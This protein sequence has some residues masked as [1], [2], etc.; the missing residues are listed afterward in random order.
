M[1]SSLRN[2]LPKKDQLS[3]FN[4]KYPN[5]KLS[6]AQGV[7]PENF[8][9]N[10][11]LFNR[12]V[13]AAKENRSVI[14]I[15]KTNTG[16]V[17]PLAKMSATGKKLATKG[18]SSESL[19]TRG[20]I[21]FLAKMAKK[22]DNVY[23]EQYV[24]IDI[25]G[26]STKKEK[27]MKKYAYIPKLVS[28]NMDDWPFKTTEAAATVLSP[29]PGSAD[30]FVVAQKAFV[31][32]ERKGTPEMEKS[33]EDVYLLKKIKAADA[34]TVT[35]GGK[36]FEIRAPWFIDPEKVGEAEC[37][38]LY[39]REDLIDE[40]I[41]VDKTKTPENKKL[42]D[43]A[44]KKI[45][46][47]PGKQAFTEAELLK[48]MVDHAAL[49]APYLQ[50]AGGP[51][52]YKNK[53]YREVRVLSIATHNNPEDKLKQTILPEAVKKV[54]FEIVADY[55]LFMI[56]PHFTQYFEGAEE[57]DQTPIDAKSYEVY[58]WSGI[59]DEII[60][61]SYFVPKFS[62]THGIASMRD[63][64]VRESI[65]AE[66]CDKAVQHGA[67]VNNLFFISDFFEPLIFV[68]PAAADIS[69]DL[70]FLSPKLFFELQSAA[71]KGRKYEV[72]EADE[73]WMKDLLGTQKS[74]TVELPAMAIQSEFLFLYNFMWAKPTI[75]EQRDP[76]PVKATKRSQAKVWDDYAAQYTQADVDALME[77]MWFDE[78][79]AELIGPALWLPNMPLAAQLFARNL[80]KALSENHAQLM[81]CS[82]VKPNTKGEAHGQLDYKDFNRYLAGFYV[83]VEHL[84]YI[85]DTAKGIL[86]SLDKVSVAQLHTSDDKKQ[87]AQQA[88]RIVVLMVERFVKKIGEKYLLCREQEVSY[89]NAT[90]NKTKADD[91]MYYM[92]KALAK[93][94]Y[95][96]QYKTQPK[97]GLKT[98]HKSDF[99]FFFERWEVEVKR[100]ADDIR[101]QKFVY[102]NIEPPLKDVIVNRLTTTVQ[103]QRFR[104]QG[105]FDPIVPING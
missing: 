18:K 5:L 37:Y 34:L 43:E 66:L 22:S 71:Q 48:T 55:D 63:L 61:R 31:N 101:K 41:D 72:K 84:R 74:A 20:S 26:Q 95:P 94:G 49:Y 21:T 4:S 85:F 59:S 56:A 19:F 79:G 68:S 12:L 32:S 44:V 58:W 96:F 80:A 28:L 83:C 35:N 33:A 103:R 38:Q 92:N 53:K 51:F 23:L 17:I 57:L 64:I 86:E 39:I 36:S 105:G 76:D 100:V 7:A 104:A 45:Q 3:T 25:L 60:Q 24:L 2:L 93:E 40:I 81:R 99:L 65:N 9:V 6:Q 78:D 87:K 10:K 73:P 16:S 102:P 11:E 30:L 14:M 67:E 15:R 70:F 8:G 97:L 90:N 82:W 91:P 62:T 77:W 13:K 46:H 29:V 54:Y 42:I 89:W 52:E 50:V 69:K 27:D 75:D 88:Y 1:M 47:E 98:E